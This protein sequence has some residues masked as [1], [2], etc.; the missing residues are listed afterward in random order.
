MFKFIQGE[1]KQDPDPVSKFGL[2]DPH[3]VKNG[4]DPQAWLK[5]GSLQIAEVKKG[6]R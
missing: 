3:P 2:P 1:C 6:F 4:P 5:L